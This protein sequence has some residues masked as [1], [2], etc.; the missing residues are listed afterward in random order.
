MKILIVEDD[1]DMS[2]IWNEELKAKKYTVK[3]AEDGERA[4]DLARSFMPELI[5]LDLILP[6]KDGMTVLQELKADPV[7]KNIVVI[8]SSNLGGDETIKKALA[9]GAADYFAKAQHPIYEI[10]DKA[11]KYITK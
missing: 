4:L 5:I 11:Q 6:K 3:I 7:T 8:V 10:I 1:K 9:L 2:W